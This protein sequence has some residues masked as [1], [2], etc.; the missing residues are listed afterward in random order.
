MFTSFKRLV[1]KNFNLLIFLRRL[2]KDFFG[3][4]NGLFGEVSPTFAKMFSVILPFFFL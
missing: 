2:Y 4:G 1:N 3:K